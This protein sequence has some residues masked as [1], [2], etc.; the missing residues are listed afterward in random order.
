MPIFVF[1][2]KYVFRGRAV[3]SG[4]RKLD[5]SEVDIIEGE[6]IELRDGLFY[7]ICK[8]LPLLVTT[9]GSS[10]LNTISN[11]EHGFS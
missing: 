11:M 10:K 4:K 3:M 9:K 6:H 7:L 1:D 2:L 5:E 8:L